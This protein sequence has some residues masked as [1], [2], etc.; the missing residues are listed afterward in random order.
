[1]F[2][3]CLRDRA[4]MVAAHSCSDVPKISVN[5]G[6][7]FSDDNFTMVKYISWTYLIFINL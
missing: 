1:M 5:V 7:C 6:G 3:D 4:K 2:L